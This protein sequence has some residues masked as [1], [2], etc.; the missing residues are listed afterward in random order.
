MP[1]R[2][3]RYY[4]SGHLHFIT[5]SCYCRR[6]LLGTPRFR[7]LF[8]GILEQTRLRYGFVVVGYVVMPEHIHLLISEPD[9]GTP[10]TI[11]Q[12]LKQ[13]FARRVLGDIRRRKD[14]PQGSLWQEALDSGQVW[15]RRFYDFVVRTEIKKI[16]KLKYIH[17]NPVRRGLVLKPEQWV[18]SS[19]RWYSLGECGPVLVNEQ[20]R[21]EM[22]LCARQ[23]FAEQTD[24]VPTL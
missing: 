12:V 8:L 22:K 3:H 4:G 13:R 5:S 10:S 24:E 6:P 18:W 7:N 23:T 14:R 1:K 19:F 15:Q 20:R 9:R 21:A 2:L 17:R 11:M 16:E